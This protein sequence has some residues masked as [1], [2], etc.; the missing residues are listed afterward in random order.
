MNKCYFQNKD[1][2]YRYTQKGM[3][4]AG[5]IELPAIFISAEPAKQIDTYKHWP[6]PVEKKNI[7]AD[8]MYQK[9]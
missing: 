4:E 1:N 9:H 3:E 7:S 2:E 6:Q 8:T 5:A